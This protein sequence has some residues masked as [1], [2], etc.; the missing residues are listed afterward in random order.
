[1]IYTI[2]DLRNL[3][4]N[5]SDN[6]KWGKDAHKISSI[7]NT[8]SSASCS[9][10]AMRKHVKTLKSILSAYGDDVS[11]VPNSYHIKSRD[12]D[13]HRIP[14]VDCV[15]KHIGQAYI[16]QSE[17]Y[18]GYTEYLGLIESHL[19]EALAECPRDAIE[20]RKL[21]KTLITEITVDRKP[22]VPMVIYEEQPAEAPKPVNVND[23]DNNGHYDIPIITKD[24]VADLPIGPIMRAARVLDLYRVSIND[25]MNYTGAGRYNGRHY[26]APLAQAAEFMAFYCPK[27][28][29]A[30]RNIRLSVQQSYKDNDFDAISNKL[31]LCDSILEIL[32]EII[33]D[34]NTGKTS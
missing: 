22:N 33:S 23:A 4:D 15:A 13:S 9:S 26:G 2:E 16:L 31:A 29:V 18:Q 25:M 5:Q 19:E 21:I 30:L 32:K 34:R 20:L 27:L 11:Y 3:V 8:I 12:T 1:M 6:S 14:C 7:I 28:S 24:D 17:F 10:C